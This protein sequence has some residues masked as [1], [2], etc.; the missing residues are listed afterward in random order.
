MRDFLLG[1]GTRLAAWAGAIIGALTLLA[2][3]LG[4]LWRWLVRHERHI[5]ARLHAFLQ[6]PRVAEFRR[7]F[8]SQIQF[9]QRRL[10]PAGCLGLHL[11]VGALIIIAA[12]WCFGVVVEDILTGDPLTVIDTQMAEWFHE[13]ATPPVTKTAIAITFLG[14]TPFLSGASLAS[15]LF[16]TWRRWWHRLLA[17]ILTM[18]GGTLLILLLKTL[19]YRQRP[20]FE[21]P[22]VTL[23]S[24]SFPSGHVMGST[25]LCGS[26]A[27][28][29]AT[30]LKA[31]RWWVLSILSAFL[32]VLL[33]ALTRI[34]L[35]VHYLSDVLGAMAA[36]LAWLAFCLTAVEIFRRRPGISEGT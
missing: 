5:T 32:F 25:L 27:F 15:A 17:L 23:A 34:Y 6:R 14:S 21:N 28:I 16:L 24:Y 18:G 10:S 19:F 9:L 8:T 11:T 31:W 35:E 1:H 7:R 2:V 13:H 4:W 22:V 12:G 20:I 26:I 36:G 29:V 33:I 3:A 30:S